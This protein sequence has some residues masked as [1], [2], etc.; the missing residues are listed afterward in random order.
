MVGAAGRFGCLE[1]GAGINLAAR[2]HA[3][4]HQAKI[5]SMAEFDHPELE[6]SSQPPPV[7]G[8]PA[9]G[10]VLFFATFAL[11]ILAAVTSIEVFVDAANMI[12]IMFLIFEFRRIPPV[13]MIVGSIL[14]IVGLIAALSAGT[15]IESVWRGVEQ[16]H[17]FLVLFGAVAFL[18]IPAATS[19]SLRAIQEMVKSQP[20]GKR[21]TYLAAAAHLLGFAF[22][23]AGI[24]LITDL[25]SRQTDQ[26]V[27]QR[28][29]RAML[30]GF[31]TVT[32]WSPFFVG[33]VLILDAWQEVTWREVA[34]YGLCLAFVLTL[35]SWLMDRFGARKSPKNLTAQ[36]SVEVPTRAW[37]RTA[38]V[39]GLLFA[40]AISLV[41]FFHFSIPVALGMVG[42]PLALAWRATM[43]APAQRLRESRSF[44]HQAIA[45]L[46]TLRG[47]MLVFV[48]ANIMGA[49]IAAVIDPQT[50]ANLI[51]AADFS[52]DAK[53]FTLALAF[54]VC[55]AL[56]IH[57]VI[58]VILIAQ[59]L[60][61][62]AIGVPPLVMVVM[63]MALWGLATNV[64]PVSATVLFVSRVANE[65]NLTVAWRW[66]APYSFAGAGLLAAIIIAGR[67]LG[68]Y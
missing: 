47:E 48:S 53:I 34:P 18:Q 3:E 8:V 36:P 40:G 25:V 24:S 56:A 17:K 54:V 51:A 41:E 30:H 21:Y 2:R 16:T 59:L 46:N 31:S 13:P 39:L 27:K 49:G 44:A 60:P 10:S 68:F 67:H 63:L 9:L 1:S 7:E 15:V 14:L 5:V 65:S 58:L 35:L 4:G 6:P 45:R 28:L 33:A 11:I 66:N 22:N 43:F 42:P 12:L 20:P 52:V 29:G 50:I 38:T 61:A 37:W 62:G 57:P 19:P 55:G 23:I 64:S 26:L 32:C